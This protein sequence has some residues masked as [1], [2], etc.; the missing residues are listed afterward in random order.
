MESIVDAVVA[1]D[2]EQRRVPVAQNSK[3][4]VELA[5]SVPLP[6]SKE[7]VCL[8]TTTQCIR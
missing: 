3:L 5:T 2:W 4:P 7:A 8:I 1:V 6:T